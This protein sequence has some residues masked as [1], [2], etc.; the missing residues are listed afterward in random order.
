MES[1]CSLQGVIA[2][3]R[4]SIEDTCVRWSIQAEG[5]WKILVHNT[6]CS[7]TLLTSYVLMAYYEMYVVYN[8]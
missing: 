4:P 8:S 1:V 3:A 2:S 5:K 6:H 7:E